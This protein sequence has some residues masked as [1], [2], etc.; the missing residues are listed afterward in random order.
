MNAPAPSVRPATADDIEELL[1]LR[2]SVLA[3]G[4]VTDAWRQTFGQDLRE[5]LGADPDLFVFVAPDPEAEGRLLA[6]AIGMA[7]RG[8]R[9]PEYPAGRW[10][11][12]M[13]VATRPHARRRGYGRAVMR[14]LVDALR[15][16]DCS[17][18]E[19]RA[20]A[21]GEALYRTL[22]FTRIP[23]GS[24][25]VLRPSPDAPTAAGMRP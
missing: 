16:A 1:D 11:R 17:S 18:I 5:R 21:E 9:G 14:A 2:V 22:G 25:M 23:S 20:T 15:A 24:Y 3:G 7:Y 8:Y 19:L 4:E 12:V 6:C 10:A 13:T